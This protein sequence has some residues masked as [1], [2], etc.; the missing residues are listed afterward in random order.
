M[1]EDVIEKK[2]VKV[3]KVDV[4]KCI[5]CRACE[6]VCSAF[7]AEPKYSSTNPAKAR[8]RL[9]MDEFNDIYIPLYAGE[10]T[11]A[12]CNG[13]NVYTI[14]GKTYDECTFCRA[15]CPSRDFFKDPDS[16][17]PLKCD[18][19]LDDPPLEEPLCVQACRCDALTYEEVEQEEE[20]EESPDEMETGLQSLVKK[21]GTKKVMES[22]ARISKEAD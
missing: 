20:K 18:M 15:S 19:C 16:G 2:T 13:R 6:L 1:V 3:I 4:D 10:Y 11:D 22:L 9:I 14:D 8:I 17:L 12:E 21:H 5:G 7:H